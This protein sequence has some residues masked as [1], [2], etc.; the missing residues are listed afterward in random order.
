VL[1]DRLWLAFF[2]E[3]FDVG[4]HEHRLD[5]LEPEA[6]AFTPI[7]ETAHGAGLGLAGVRGPDVDGE[8]VARATP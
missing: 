6:S 4:G 1:L 3:L 5:L 7:Q 8:E 2:C